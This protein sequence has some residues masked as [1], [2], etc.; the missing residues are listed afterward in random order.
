MIWSQ[1]D[2][3]YSREQR[4]AV[5]GGEGAVS[6]VLSGVRECGACALGIDSSLAVGVGGGECGGREAVSTRAARDGVL[7]AVVVGFCAGSAGQGPFGLGNTHRPTATHF[8]HN[9]ISITFLFIKYYPKH[10]S[11]VSRFSHEPLE[12]LIP[13]QLIAAFIT[14]E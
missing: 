9:I 2:K 8:K 4:E 11:G 12:P 14:M 3:C 6:G 13:W 10:S 5:Y 7:G 1:G